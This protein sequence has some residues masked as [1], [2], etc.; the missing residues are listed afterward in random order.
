MTCY[1]Q[2]RQVLRG[3]V[4]PERHGKL[5]KFEIGICAI[6]YYSGSHELSGCLAQ[7]CRTGRC[8]NRREAHAPR[9]KNPATREKPEA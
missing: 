8:S 3:P 2:V 7:L 6:A 9:S 5:I 1:R 4:F